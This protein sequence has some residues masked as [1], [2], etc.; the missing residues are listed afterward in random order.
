MFGIMSYHHGTLVIAAIILL[1]LSYW[2]SK[3]A[4][5]FIK[6][7]NEENSSDPHRQELRTAPQWELVVC[8]IILLLALI[9]PLR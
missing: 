9:L 8:I 6:K 4:N 3:E 2:Q 7:V 5:V 1:V